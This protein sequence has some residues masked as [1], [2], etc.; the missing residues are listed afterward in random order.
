MDG[1]SGGDSGGTFM[2]GGGHDSGGMPLH[3]SGDSNFM[4]GPNGD[5]AF[6]DGSALGNILSNSTQNQQGF[7]AHLLGLDHDGGAHAGHSPAHGTPA[8]H[9]SS[10]A[11]WSSTLQSLKFSDFTHG[12]V[13]TPA[14]GML[15]LFAGFVGWLFVLYGIRHNESL[16]NA[17]IGVGPPSQG[18]GAYTDRRI[19]NRMREA[20]PIKTAAFSDLSAQPAQPQGFNFFNFLPP[21]AG[22]QEGAP[23]LRFDTTHVSDLAP[24]APVQQPAFSPGSNQPYGVP[25]A[26]DSSDE[27][28]FSQPMGGPGMSIAA[29]VSAPFDSYSLPSYQAP[30]SAL[31]PTS[32]GSGDL[33]RYSISSV[34]N[35]PTRKL[36]FIVNH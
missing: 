14:I 34:Q 3:T 10:S 22:P 30:T 5:Q 36:K 15:C 6:G 23:S 1:G 24:Q 9:V 11:I 25:Q 12:L 13:F 17:V 35:G 26:A 21:A 32:F 33:S 16:A 18:V 2:D 29:P 4:P 31:S 20:M 7:L 27:I 28:S 19:A 8:G